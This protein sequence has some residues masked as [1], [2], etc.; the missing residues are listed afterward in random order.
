MVLYKMAIDSETN[1]SHQFI[2]KK[3]QLPIPQPA[4]FID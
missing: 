1:P 3:Q 4:E 2:I